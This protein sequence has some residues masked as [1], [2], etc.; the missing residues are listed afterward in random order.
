MK[1]LKILSILIFTVFLVG[2]VS[3]I[4]FNEKWENGLQSISITE[5]DSATFI[6][7]GH[8]VSDSSV[9]I[10]IN[11]YDTQS[12]LV[13]FEDNMIISN[14]L[15]DDKNGNPVEDTTCFYKSYTFNGDIAPGNYRVQVIGYDSFGSFSP[16]YP[17][18][19]TVNAIIIPQNNVPQITSTAITQ[20]NERERY[21]YDVDATDADADVE[22][23]IYSLTQ[24]P[25]WLSIDPI[26]GLITG[27]APEVDSDTTYD[28]EVDASDGKDSDTQSYTLTVRDVPEQDTTPPV[29]YLNGDA[30]VD[31]ELRT[32]YTDAG[33]TAYDQEDGYITNQIVVT[34]SV[35]TNIIGTYVLTYNVQDNAGNFA[36]PVTR[37]VS[38]I[39]AP[40]IDTNAPVITLS[41]NDPENVELGTNYID[42]GAIAYDQEDGYITNQIVV[43]GSVNTNII[44]TYVL[45][46][47][48]QDNAGN[49][50]SPVTRTV[51]VFDPTETIP[52][53]IT[54][55]TPE[56]D[57]EY[58][59]E[60]TF[61]V[62]VDE[63]AEVT[64]RLDNGPTI[65][66]DYQGVSG[67]VL[68]FTHDVNLKDGDYEVTFYATDIAGN[69]AE[70]T[71][72]FSVDAD[73]EKEERDRKSN[74]IDTDNYEEELY[75]DQ[76]KQKKVIY[77]EEEQPD[78]ELTFWQK[79]VAW[80]KRIFG[81]S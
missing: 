54:V 22:T 9:E 81:F 34:G 32:T 48:V 53:T 27:T 62:E 64:F 75:L 16:Q 37:T 24:A 45:T 15:C 38:V 6:I 42:A 74:V 31:V 68:T 13:I 76:F 69:P 33:A 23:L 50:A 65:T 36:A 49:S 51:N 40:I 72:E 30:F 73:G 26:T 17:L 66:M 29:I 78:V 4:V 61:E 14:S 7:S 71:V 20:V 44:G 19:L 25:S 39:P 21:I 80:L 35:N 11:L 18:S 5:G 8:S 55:I 3:A 77:L 28:I 60:L 2:T 67:G 47:N 70:V 43:T 1:T 58:D 63:I 57:E 52:P 41:G 10:N 46:Y 59:S 79:F 12:N 56:E